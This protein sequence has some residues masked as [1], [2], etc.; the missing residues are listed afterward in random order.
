MLKDKKNSSDKINLILLK[1]IGS[2][3]IDKKYKKN[4]LG[5]FLKNELRN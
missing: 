5:I 4:N 2:P 1:K 3:I